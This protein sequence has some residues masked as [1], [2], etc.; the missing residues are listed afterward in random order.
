MEKETEEEKKN[1]RCV[2]MTRPHVHVIYH[3][4]DEPGPEYVEQA[5]RAGASNWNSRVV[6]IFDGVEN[7]TSLRRLPTDE[8][9]ESKMQ[10][11]AY[12]A[13]KGSGGN[14]S[15]Q[16]YAVRAMQQ[17]VARGFTFVTEIQVVECASYDD[18]GLVELPLL[19]IMVPVRVIG[20]AKKRVRYPKKPKKDSR[21]VNPPNESYPQ[22]SHAL[23]TPTFQETLD[24]LFATAYDP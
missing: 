15:A 4:P 19:G 11:D 21:A 23:Y 24:E 22:T 1:G 3:A 13:V 6:L 18:T 7:L 10:R 12:K 17:N 2:E 8:Q 9:T 16:R 5:V 20:A 14:T